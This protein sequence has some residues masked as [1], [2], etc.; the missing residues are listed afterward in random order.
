M[1][2]QIGQPRAR[3]DP[4]A[5][6]LPP[7]DRWLRHHPWAGEGFLNLGY[8]FLSRIPMPRKVA[9]V[10]IPTFTWELLAFSCCAVG[11]VEPHLSPTARALFPTAI[12]FN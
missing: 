7:M 2:T 5:S 9:Q 8:D 10:G 1:R 12:G 3:K 4:Q 6:K 11:Q